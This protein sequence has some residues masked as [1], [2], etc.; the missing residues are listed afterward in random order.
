YYGLHLCSKI[1]Y[2]DETE[3][4]EL[5]VAESQSKLAYANDIHNVEME[6]ADSPA[7]LN[8]KGA[9]RKEYKDRS[10][11]WIHFTKTSTLWGH[12]NKCESNPTKPPTD[13]THLAFNTM[14]VVETGEMKHTLQ[15]WKFDQQ[16][17]R[18]AIA[19]MIIIDELPL[20]FVENEGFRCMKMCQ[21]ALVVPSRS[22]ITR[23]CYQLY[24]DQKAKLKAQL[25]KST[26]TSN[27]YLDAISCIDSVLKECL[28]SEDNDLKKMAMKMKLKFD[29][30]WGDIK[31]FNL[32]VFIASVFYPRTK[33]EYLQVT[34]N[35]MYGDDEGPKVAEL[36]EKALIALFNDY[37]RIYSNQNVRSA[38]S[39]SFDDATQ[40]FSISQ[41]VTDRGLFGSSSDA[42]TS[43]REKN[44]VEVKRRKTESGVGKDFQ[45]TFSTGGR[46]LDSF[47][48]SLS[49]E[50]VQA[51]ICCQDWVR[52]GDV[53]VNLEENIDD[54][55]KFEDGNLLWEQPQMLAMEKMSEA[56]NGCGC[57]KM[58]I[59]S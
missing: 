14:R 33:M 25:Q 32:L 35:G 18:N 53:A 39:S 9:K 6:V 57:L 23:D 43:L 46:V 5:E 36:C 1:R 11:V 16:K 41:S 29:K 4:I 42:I 49:P 19:E 59:S 51:L 24:V 55:E 38:S 10:R 7:N 37:K 45:S 54:L 47:R 52:S 26:Q 28:A 50:T 56:A 22:T 40:S 13:Q 20:K 12:L 21:P 2:A 3:D 34:L 27:T 30:Y 17:C 58:D 31:K 44:L 48:S 8:S 15:A